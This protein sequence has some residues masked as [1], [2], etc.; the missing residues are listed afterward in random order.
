MLADKH[1]L[2]TGGGS[3]IGAAI[4]RKLADAGAAVSLAGRR[5]AP[6]NALAATLPRATAIV[7]DVTREAECEAMLAT[8]RAAH[9]PVDIL[10]ASAGAAESAPI[11]KLDLARWLCAKAGLPDLTRRG[12]QASR[13]V[14]IASTAG[15]KGYAYV[16]AYCA[17]KHGIVG[18]TRALA[19]ELAP[20]GVTVNAAAGSFARNHRGNHRAVG[21]GSPRGA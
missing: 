19:V 17:A 10:V 8:A 12:A 1:A 2:I 4:A 13:I 21:R 11:T 5:E 7:A 9:G 20:C 3:G 15:L 16:A 18:L 14:F 6:L